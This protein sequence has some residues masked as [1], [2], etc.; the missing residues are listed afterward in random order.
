MLT[1]CNSPSQPKIHPIGSHEWARSAVVQVANHGESCF[2]CLESGMRQLHR[3]VLEKAIKHNRQRP[4]SSTLRVCEDEC[5]RREPSTFHSWDIEFL[6]KVINERLFFLFKDRFYPDGSPEMV[7]NPMLYSKK[8]SKDWIISEF[9]KLTCRIQAGQISGTGILVTPNFACSLYGKEFC[10]SSV[11]NRPSVVSCSSDKGVVNDLYV[12]SAGH[13]LREAIRVVKQRGW[14]SLTITCGDQEIPLGKY[15]EISA[16]VNSIKDIG[17]VT[18]LN[19]EVI[20]ERRPIHVSKSTI[21]NN[22]DLHSAKWS[23]S[24]RRNFP[25]EHCWNMNRDAFDSKLALKLNPLLNLGQDFYKYNQSFYLSKDGGIDNFFSESLHG[26]SSGLSGYKGEEIFVLGY[27]LGFENIQITSG[28][29]TGEY[30]QPRRILISA[31]ISPGSSGSPVFDS[32]GTLIGIAIGT[33][34]TGQNVN[35]IESFF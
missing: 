23:I 20:E 22:W 2:E 1:S 35:V 15:P 14:S 29:V 33:H 10:S 3:D 26:T 17:I 21:L 9:S 4:Y 27:P 34:P 12:L 11:E 18:G 16:E 30:H 31:P 7:L 24:H 13:V 25:L 19:S 6:L 5:R 32:K 8:I 28:I